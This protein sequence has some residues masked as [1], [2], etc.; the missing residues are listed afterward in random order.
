MPKTMMTPKSQKAK[1]KPQFPQY[2][3][4]TIFNAKKV[5]SKEI[6]DFKF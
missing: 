3:F 1:T 4:L 2:P 5:S 6:Y